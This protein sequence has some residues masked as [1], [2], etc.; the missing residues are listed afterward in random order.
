MRITVLTVADC[1]NA[2]PALDLVTAAL[3]GREAEVE[4]VE[5]ADDAEAVRLGMY[6][7]PTIL[8]DGTDPFAPPGAVPSLSCRLY[9]G[10][11]GTV[12][13]VPDEAALRQ[14]LA[15]NAAPP[16][17]IGAVSDC[18]APAVPVAPEAPGAAIAPDA[19]DIVGRGGRGRRAP[20]ERGLRAVHQ[21]V[22]RHFAATGSA[23]DAARL[24]PV[25]AAAGR[26]A[27]EVLAELADE[28]FLTLDEAGR[29]R[30]AYPFSAVPTRH[31]VR[32]DSGVA[33]WSMCAADALGIPVMLGQD[34]VISS[35]DPVSGAPVTVTST[36]GTLRWEPAG[37]VVFLG[38][39]PGGGPAA[40][41]CCE[42]LNFFADPMNADV[43]ASEHPEI[44]GRVID[45]ADA[46]QIGQEIFGPLLTP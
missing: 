1:P 2:R 39:R 3:D 7:S 19:L 20:A 8:I 9:R 26:N 18:C 46:G 30:A 32:L 44:R 12:S 27:G 23:P 37:A 4:L 38:H 15:G 13:G 40:D 22:L 14:A 34:A 21:E 11:E 24:Q 35:T 29:I 41:I 17:G 28:D 42:A 5:V 10:A 43:W 36:D 6:G 16:H 25:A 45:G 31:R 33:V